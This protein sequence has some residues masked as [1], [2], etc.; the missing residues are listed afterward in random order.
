MGNICRSPS[1]EGFFCHHLEKSSISKL[2]SA[3]SAGTHS[4]HIGNA[5]DH[6]AISEAGQFGVDISQLR[7]RKITASDF[8]RF[9]LIIA[10]DQHN[11]SLIEQLQPAHSHAQI[12]LMMDY[13]HSEGLSEVPDPYYGSQEDFTFM[14]RLLD[15]ASR[16]LLHKLESS[17]A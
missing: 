11:L 10:M 9:D 5:P 6:R 17:L 14:C 2:V 8:G 16:N 15:K 12:A 4:Y 3:D 7:A 13:D 1:A